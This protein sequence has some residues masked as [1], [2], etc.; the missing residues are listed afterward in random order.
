MPWRGDEV[1]MEFRKNDYVTVTI[2]DI[3]SGG[4]GIGKA[5]GFTLFVKDAVMGDT[6]EAKIVKSKK[7]YAYARLERV[8]EPSPFRVEPEC[9]C[10]RQC[11]GCQLQALSYQEQLRFKQ[12]KIRDS[13]IRIGG[14]AP[15][16]VDACMEPI[17]GMEEPFRYRNKAQHP[18]GTDRDGRLV[19]GFY[20]GRTHSI[21][22]NTDCLLGA[23]ENREI[24]ECIL[25]YMRESHVPAYNEATGEGLVRHILIR[26][27]F[28]SG[29]IMVCLVVNA[30]K[31]FALP[32]Q[33]RLV[34]GLRK[35]P[36]MASISVSYNNEKTNVIM[37]R[38]LCTLWGK[39]T[40]SDT[41]R[42]RDMSAPG[43]PA[44][45]EELA[46][47]ISPL[48]F[49]QVNPVQTEKLY[50][51]ALEYAGLT[52]RETVWDLYC[53]I[54]TISLFMARDAGKVYGVEA[55][56]QAVEDARENAERNG[57]KNAEFLVGRAEEVLAGFFGEGEPEAGAAGMCRNLAGACCGAL[58]KP[59]VI[60]VDPPR[61]GCDETCLSAMLKAKPERIVYVSCD[62]A[63]LARDLNF[64]C[65]GGYGLQ[66]VRGVDQ[67]GMTVHCEAVCLL[68]KLHPEQ[69]TEV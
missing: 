14:F 5:G 31:G 49:Y 16:R 33:E 28:A 35:I 68:S 36:G 48:S 27:G 13:L 29:E 1:S 51:L 46:F 65:G 67:F 39:G 55:V 38:E 21:I 66:R 10:H 64:L 42:V 23:A 57:I 18:V 53:G 34:E 17:I 63:T 3:G 50:S 43:L 9:A 61:K 25:A 37:G 54:G 22:P 8:L 47:N 6:V 44:A 41:L 19:T 45:G 30:R 62:P 24:L 69:N 4:E 32:G 11:G 7:N 15:D 2:E 58:E 40:I 52:G 26:K 56:P 12:R 20:A 59:D 60:V